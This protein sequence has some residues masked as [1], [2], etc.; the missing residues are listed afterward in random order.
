MAIWIH[1]LKFL[2]W[3][4]MIDYAPTVV[5]GAQK[6]WQRVRKKNSEPSAPV[7]SL[8]QSPEAVLAELQQQVAELRTQQVEL[9]NLVKELADQNQRLVQA[10]DVLRVRT[11]ILLFGFI[12]I[13]IGLAALSLR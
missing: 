8:P 5:S 6:L 11:K 3:K 7:D 4:D 9:S 10:V 13:G 1:A 12:A 2:P